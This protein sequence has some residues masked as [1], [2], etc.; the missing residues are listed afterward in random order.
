MGRGS[1]AHVRRDSL[2]GAVPQDRMWP[3][4]T[5]QVPDPV[6]SGSG[7]LE[8]CFPLMSSPT[9]APGTHNK[10]SHMKSKILGLLA[11]GL[12]G[13]P[14]AAHAF[15]VPAW[16]LNQATG[17][18]NAS[19]SF[20][21]VFTVGGSNIYVTAIGALDRPT[22]GSGLAGDGFVSTGGIPVGIYR[23]SDGVL[24]ASTNVVSTDPLTGLYRYSSVALTLLANTA[25]RVVAVNLDDPYNGTP[26]N[27]ANV[28]PRITWNRW[29]LCQ[30]TVLTRCDD[31]T[32]GGISWMANFMIGEEVP[33]PVPLPAAAWLLLSGLGGLGLL[34][35][36]RKA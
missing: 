17:I 14:I 12:L 28:D 4:Q 24:L 27:P 30:T 31:V 33:E 7:W 6:R 35:R 2:H 36:R 1:P 5:T 20:G 9:D 23:E 26:G 21:E 25:Y 8:I 15:E 34:G 19:Y 29:G 16:T 13:G 32:G 22:N 11:V 18:R 10:G 3:I